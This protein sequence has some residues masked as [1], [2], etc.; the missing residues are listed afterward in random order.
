MNN[1]K[2]KNE[3]Y[4]QRYNNEET[5]TNEFKSTNKN[6]QIFIILNN[7]SIIIN[8]AQGKIKDKKNKSLKVSKEG[9]L[10]KIKK[11]QANNRDKSKRKN[12]YPNH[13][14]KGKVYCFLYINNYPQLTLG[15]QF[16]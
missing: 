15:P 4:I 5:S 14:T 11:K 8:K 3:K 1:K 9:E 12:K 16:Y 2:I 6:K 7:K 13:F 10:R